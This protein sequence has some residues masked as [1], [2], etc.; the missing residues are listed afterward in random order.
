MSINFEKKP[1]I[2]EAYKL[3]IDNILDK[4]CLTTLYL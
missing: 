4:N 3:L 1:V 2:F